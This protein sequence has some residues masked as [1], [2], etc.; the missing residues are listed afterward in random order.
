MFADIWM[1]NGMNGAKAYKGAYGTKITEATARVNASRLLTNANIWN[2]IEE[3]RK[4]IT[5]KTTVTVID[6]VSAL[7]RIVDTC[8][9]VQMQIEAIKQIA[10]LLG[11]EA[12]IKLETNN[13][14][15]EA[16]SKLTKDEQKAI[17]KF[18]AKKT[19]SKA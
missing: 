8:S 19:T 10:K 12:P 6:L 11:L 15:I 5:E 2:Y 3:K 13:L 9:D 18:I 14:N 17:N 16:N 7:K 4:E 1:M